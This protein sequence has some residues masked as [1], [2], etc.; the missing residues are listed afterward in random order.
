LL[1]LTGLLAFCACRI[2]AAGAAG[3]DISSCNAN[4]ICG[5]L[6]M[7]S[8]VEDLERHK[9]GSTAERRGVMRCR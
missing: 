7:M 8:T 4:Q 1:L 2:P 3:W 5:P 9:A 6:Q